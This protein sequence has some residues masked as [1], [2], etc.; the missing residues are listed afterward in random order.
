MSTSPLRILPLIL[1]PAVITLVVTLARLFL[2]FQEAPGWLASKEAGGAG[3]L[4]GISWLPLVFGPFFVLRIGRSLEGFG[5]VLKRLAA[6]L[7]VYGLAARI[8]VAV[9]TVFAILG[10]WG[11]HYDKFPPDMADKSE[12]M[13]IA[14]T[15]GF[16]LG[17]W[18]LL[19]TVLVGC[20]AG[21]LTYAICKPKP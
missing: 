20:I 14:L 21:S 9:I 16:Q 5:R 7:A 12:G 13:K 18:A 4:I 19:W 1:V 10:D 2:E 3:A 11:T 15:F 8:P 6:T 17:F